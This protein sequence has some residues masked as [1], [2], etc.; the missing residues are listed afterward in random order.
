MCQ[1]GFD[2]ERGTYCTEMSAVVRTEAVAETCPAY[3]PEENQ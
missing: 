2:T 3:T 1:L